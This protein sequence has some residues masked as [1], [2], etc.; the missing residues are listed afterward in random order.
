MVLS[1]YIVSLYDIVFYLNDLKVKKNIEKC[2]ELIGSS[3]F[4]R[5][6]C[7]CGNVVS[8]IECCDG[9]SIDLIES[10][11][12]QQNQNFQHYC[13]RSPIVLS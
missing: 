6:T 12:R 7:F 4:W 8:E 10:K 3:R 5:A 9:R 2:T 11:V 13:L 1:L